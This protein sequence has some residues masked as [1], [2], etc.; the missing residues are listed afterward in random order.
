MTVRLAAAC[1]PDGLM[2]LVLVPSF[3]LSIHVIWYSG[4]RESA[5]L[6]GLPWKLD[7]IPHTHPIPT[8][9]PMAIPTEFPYTHNPRTLYFTFIVIDDITKHR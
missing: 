2:S 9:K 8:E 5:N 3:H 1:M 4:V 6:A 7:L